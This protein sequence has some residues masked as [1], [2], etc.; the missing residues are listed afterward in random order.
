MT[1]AITAGIRP[2][3]RL[4]AAQTVVVTLMSFPL[5]GLLLRVKANE[6]GK[7]E[8]ALQWQLACNWTHHVEHW[9]DRRLG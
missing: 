3:L 2:R 7:K 6:G 9:I 5:I 8:S 1:S 4:P